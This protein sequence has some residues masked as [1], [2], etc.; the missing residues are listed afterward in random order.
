MGVKR[1]NTR[2]K[3]RA[4]PNSV[5]PLTSHGVGLLL[6]TFFPS[7]TKN[8]ALPLHHLVALPNTKA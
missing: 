8:V 2:K 5:F 1:N 7:H 4:K 3:R 6:R